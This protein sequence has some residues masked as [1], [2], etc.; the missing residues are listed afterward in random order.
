MDRQVAQ[1]VGTRHDP[2]LSMLSDEQRMVWMERVLLPIDGRESKAFGD[3]DEDI[4]FCVDVVGHAV[5][6]TPREQGRVE[7]LAGHAPHG[8]V[9]LQARQ[10]DRLA[11]LVTHWVQRGGL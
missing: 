4:T 2:A 8:T 6:G 1:S 5:S 9:P 11:G 10:V 3:Q 7:V